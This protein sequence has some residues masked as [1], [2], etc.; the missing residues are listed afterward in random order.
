MLLGDRVLSW[1]IG[2]MLHVL[3]SS[4]RSRGTGEGGKCVASQQAR[5]SSIAVI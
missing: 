4:S 3:G 2:D 5:G 1:R